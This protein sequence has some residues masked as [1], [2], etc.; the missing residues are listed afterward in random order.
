VTELFFPLGIPPA[1]SF[2]DD[3]VRSSETSG[4]KTLLFSSDR[5]VPLFRS[6]PPLQ[7]APLPVARD[8][9]PCGRYPRQ[10]AVCEFNTVSNSSPISFG[11]FSLVLPP[12][13]PPL[14][15]FNPLEDE[16]LN[17]SP[18]L[19]GPGPSDLLRPPPPPPTQHSSRVFS[20]RDEPIP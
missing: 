13:S 11:Q 7:C 18:P 4:R 17:D 3:L 9:A 19:L 20:G 14:A 15:F 16:L 12:R 10:F 5:Y 2:T 8:R 6:P 1:I